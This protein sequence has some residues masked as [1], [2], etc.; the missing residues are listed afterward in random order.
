M[1]ELQSNVLYYGDNLDVLRRHFP[2]GSVDLIYLDPPF[3]SNRSYNVLF[4]ES[5]G[6]ASDAQLEAFEDTW[7]W[8]EA[9]ELAYHEAV[10]GQH[11]QVGR[12]LRAMVE[13]LGRNDVTAYLAMMAVRLVELHRVLKETGSLY[14]HCDPTASHYLKVLLDAVFGPTNFRNE[15]M[16]KRSYSHGSAKRYGPLHDTI[17]FFSKSDVYSWTDPRAEQDPEYVA[18][19]FGAVDPESGRRFEPITLT[20][21]GVR[22]GESGKPWRG[23]DPTAV[24]RHWA[25]PGAI[26]DKLDIRGAT[27]QEKLD[28]LDALGMIYWPEKQGGTPRLKHYADELGRV[29][30]QDV[31][32]D[33][34]PISA[35]AKERLGYAT[36]KPLAL[37]ERI[38]SAS[39]S[40]GEVV[41]DPLC[42]CG[43]A[44][45]AAH[46]LGRRWVG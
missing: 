6:A 7:H 3:S 39:S 24:G 35:Q 32:T 45:H 8:G 17:L 9:A 10:T 22:H 36:Q 15:I 5:T 38:I 2:D 34:R 29:A 14:L 30:L 31:W 20:G 25:L 40:P 19:H 1:P 4:K 37:L 12:M 21:A 23:I 27:M 16:W 18:K 13:G 44:V 41:L 46:K 28:A 43:T 11:Q 42:G 26:I 33:I